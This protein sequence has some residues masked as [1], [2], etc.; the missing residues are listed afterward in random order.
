MA[1]TLKL[2]TQVWQWLERLAARRVATSSR[3]QSEYVKWR[4]R[5]M[6]RRAAAQIGIY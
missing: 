4:R 6:I 5:E 3:V 2:V 1:S